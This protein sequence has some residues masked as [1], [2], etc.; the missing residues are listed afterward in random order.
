MTKG[1]GLQKRLI[2]SERF[3]AWSIISPHSDET[4]RNYVRPT[5]RESIDAFL[6]DNDPDHNWKFW[7]QRG[8]R[9][10]WVMVEPLSF[11]KKDN[12]DGGV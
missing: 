5:R 1:Y 12:D 9:A 8:Y 4:I 6:K 3:G 11:D 7:Y 2:Q 10:T